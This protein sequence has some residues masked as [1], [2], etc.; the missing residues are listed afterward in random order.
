MFPP[1]FD[2]SFSHLHSPI[3]VPICCPICFPII[4]EL[5][6]FRCSPHLFL[7]GWPIGC[8]RWID[9][10]YCIG[11]LYPHVCI[12]SPILDYSHCLSSMLYSCT[13]LVR[14]THSG[15]HFFLH[16]WIPH[17]FGLFPISDPSPIFAPSQCFTPSLD[18]SPMS[19]PSQ[20]CAPSLDSSL[21]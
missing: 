7:P 20:C 17:L 21:F 14:L 4:L 3:I 16:L 19:A 15:F 12:P 1:S 9:S 8:F 2:P 6:V 11:F 18:P 5:L 13:D 10:H